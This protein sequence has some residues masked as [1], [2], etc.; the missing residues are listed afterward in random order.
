MAV[1]AAE[2]LSLAIGDGE[3]SE[4]FLML[5]G[6]TLHRFEISQQAVVQPSI[7]ADS[8]VNAVGAT[9]RKLTIDCTLVAN[10]HAA[11]DRLRM[12]ALS[13][14]PGNFILQLNSGEIMSGAA[15]VTDYRENG[16]TGEVKTV[17]CHLES[18]GT[19]TH[20]TS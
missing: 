20:S 16:K 14:G 15:L 17:Q 19:I 2:A 13:D 9:A 6:V 11:I 5:K 12:L 4:S 7:A 18:T 3:L 10:P 1:I 8:W